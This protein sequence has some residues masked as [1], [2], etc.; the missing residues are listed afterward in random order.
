MAGAADKAEAAASASAAGRPCGH[1]VVE[2][3]V[4]AE[5]AG[6]RLLVRLAHITGAGAAA[7]TG[8]AL[9]DGGGAQRSAGICTE[10]RELPTRQGPRRLGR[11]RETR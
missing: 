4:L 6:A 3:V 1:R 9:S 2:R 5:L 10:H 7:V 8:A 11:E